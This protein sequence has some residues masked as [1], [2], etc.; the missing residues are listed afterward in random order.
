MLI[1]L[2]GVAF[3]LGNLLFIANKLD[4]MSRLW[5][6][7]WM[8]DVISGKDAGLIVLGQVCLMLGYGAIYRHYSR[9]HPP[10]INAL[11]VLCGGGILLA[12]G[13]TS[14]ISGLPEWAEALFVLVFAGLLFL[15]VGLI[16]W[17]LLTLRQSNG[18]WLI[19]FT[20]VMGGLGFIATSGEETRAIFLVFR[21]LFA[22]GMMGM[23]VVLMLEK[24]TP[25]AKKFA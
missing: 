3:V 13:H 17:G 6:G 20:G 8:T 24:P 2:G 15:V 5:L 19:L 1:K 9:L 4:E 22:L 16:W 10:G 12:V 7:G 23:G 25:Q 18:G 14:F 21:T 11:K